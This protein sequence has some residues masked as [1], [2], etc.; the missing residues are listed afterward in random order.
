MNS[1][2]KLKRADKLDKYRMHLLENVPLND[3]ETQM[4]AKYRR[5]ISLMSVSYGRQHTVKILAEETGLSESQCY[6]ILR[7][8]LKLYGDVSEVDKN[9]LRF[10]MYENF[11][12][13]ASMAR[14]DKDYAAMTKALERASELYGLF[15][16]TIEG[17]D[18]SKFLPMPII[19][20]T[21]PEVLKQNQTLDISHE[22]VGG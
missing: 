13:A 4:L 16:K 17:L 5:S 1:K 22:E 18:P 14:A 12:L 7:D 9:G 3:E 21:S 15:D 2:K 11:M 19:F 6:M 8:A 20:T 10:I